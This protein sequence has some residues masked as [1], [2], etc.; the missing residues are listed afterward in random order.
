[1][2]WYTAEPTKLES[3]EDTKSQQKSDLTCSAIF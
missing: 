1:M 2:Q 3:N